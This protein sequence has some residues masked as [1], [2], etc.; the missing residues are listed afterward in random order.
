M[1]T[2]VAVSGGYPGEYQK[3]LEIKGIDDINP[4]DSVL[5][6]MGTILQDG[7]TLT[8][9]GRVFCISSYGRSVFDAV[10]ISKD[11]MQ[12][13]SFTGMEYRGDIGYEFE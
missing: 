6:H 1:C 7:E 11:E 13:V 4:E 5:F 12:K 10:E 2:V 3:G 9:G 8:N